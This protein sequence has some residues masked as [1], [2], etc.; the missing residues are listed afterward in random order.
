MV[1]SGT[2]IAYWFPEDTVF[3]CGTINYGQ[4]Y[5]AEP[6]GRGWLWRIQGMYCIIWINCDDMDFY[7]Y[8][9]SISLYGVSLHSIQPSAYKF[10][11][12]FWCVVSLL[13]KEKVMSTVELNEKV[14]GLVASVKADVQGLD[15]DSAIDYVTAIL[16]ELESFHSELWDKSLDE[17]DASVDEEDDEDEDE[18][19]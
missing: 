7:E 13:W 15:T 2:V 17:Y 11:L 19:P 18:L 12:L 4:N 9:E 3:G 1:Y 5:S 16:D 8:R 10:Q 6:V 14:E